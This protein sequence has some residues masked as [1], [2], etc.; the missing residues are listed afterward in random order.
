MASQRSTRHT[1]GSLFPA[2]GVIRGEIVTAGERVGVRGINPEPSD[3]SPRESKLTLS[4]WSSEISPSHLMPPHPGP[5]PHSQAGSEFLADSGGEGV[6]VSP[7][8]LGEVGDSLWATRV[9]PLSMRA[10]L[11]LV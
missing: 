8:D 7:T 11:G 2:I 5:L 6:R 4:P 3:D 9:E 10:C 1:S